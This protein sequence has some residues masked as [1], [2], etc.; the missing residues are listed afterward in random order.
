MAAIIRRPLAALSSQ[1]S[2]KTVAP[3]PL[4]HS[5]TLELSAG[6]GFKPAPAERRDA[7]ATKYKN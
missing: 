2:D 5:K 4:A 7:G 1:F 6:A 3:E